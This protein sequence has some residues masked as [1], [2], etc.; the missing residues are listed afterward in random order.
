MLYTLIIVAVV[1][2][3]LREQT[4]GRRVVGS[5]PGSL[6]THRVEEVDS[7]Y[8][9]RA[10]SHPVGVV[11]TPPET[12]SMLVRVYEDQALSTKCVYESFT[13]FREGRESVSDN[14][15]RERPVTFLSDENIEK[16]SKLIMKDRRLT[17]R[18]IAGR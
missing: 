3:W 15:R 16:V 10:Q 13:R 9:C 8:I 2:W 7:C 1:V 14:P 17:V 4:L 6:K 12:Y 18:I 5:D 11:W